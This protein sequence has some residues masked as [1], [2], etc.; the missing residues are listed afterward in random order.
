MTSKP[1]AAAA[2]NRKPGRYVLTNAARMHAKHPKTFDAP[3]ADELSS[4]KRGSIVKVCAEFESSEGCTGERFWVRVFSV[5]DDG[6]I[7]GKVNN[8]LVHTE[9]H[10]LKNL[11]SITFERRNILA[12]S[13][14]L[15]L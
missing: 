5:L 10:G 2:S 1:L 14:G 12:V 9:Q 4:L 15:W 13:D 3:S 7:I 6:I 11:K 8:H